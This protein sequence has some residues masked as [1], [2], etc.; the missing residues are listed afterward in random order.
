MFAVRGPDLDKFIAAATG[1]LVESAPAPMLTPGIHA[2]YDKGVAAF[3]GHQAVKT[4][5]QG[6][7]ADGANRSPAIFFE[8]D[9]EQFLADESLGNEIFGAASLLVHCKDVAQM[10]AIAEKLE[11]QLTATLHLDPAD[12]EDARTLLPVLERKVGR[13]LANGWPTGVEV[14]HA[15][16]HGGPFPATSD[17]RTTSVGTMAIRRY[18]RPVSYQ[19]LPDGLLPPELSNDGV[20]TLPHLL[21]G[22]RN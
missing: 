13:I 8:T 3:A 2:A 21:D 16:V 20:K 17:S 19:D 15:M 11:G 4:V 10:V 7:P 14:S 1:S 9:A 5:A 6:K 18:L 12:H 22:V